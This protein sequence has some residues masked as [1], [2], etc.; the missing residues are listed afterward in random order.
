MKLKEAVV[1]WR[2]VGEYVSWD[3]ADMVRLATLLDTPQLSV[4]VVGRHGKHQVE[5]SG[6]EKK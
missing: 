1:E 5:V 6:P 4:R 2:Q 3:Q